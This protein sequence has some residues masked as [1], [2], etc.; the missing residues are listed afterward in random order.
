MEAGLIEIFSKSSQI[1]HSW[2]E[3]KR[4]ILSARWGRRREGTTIHLKNSSL[5]KCDLE[6]SKKNL[7]LKTGRKEQ[8]KSLDLLISFDFLF[9]LFKLI[10][11]VCKLEGVDAWM[12]GGICILSIFSALRR[13]ISWSLSV[14]A[15]RR[16]ANSSLNKAIVVPLKNHNHCKKKIYCI[17]DKSLWVPISDVIEG[18]F[19]AILPSSFEESCSDFFTEL[20]SLKRRVWRSWTS[21][22][23]KFDSLR[24]FNEEESM[25]ETPFP[26]SRPKKINFCSWLLADY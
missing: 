14:K 7:G 5:I 23:I 1:G 17:T 4:S 24:P 13:S 10:E 25:G 18:A 19:R 22:G 16:A 8:K 11:I 12:G 15:S 9:D 21:P 20:S 6:R 26:L 3:W 2:V